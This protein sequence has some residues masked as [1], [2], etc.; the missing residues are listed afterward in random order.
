VSLI[1]ESLRAGYA[2]ATPVLDG[3]TVSVERGSVVALLGPN[4]SGKSTLTRC[5]ARALRPLGGRV[6]A[7]GDDLWALPAREAA[8]RV[9]YVGQENPMPFAFTVAELVRL[10]A[11]AASAGAAER[12]A[13][14][15]DAMEVAHLAGRSVVALSGGERQRA[16]VA[17]ALAQDADYLLL[18][19]PTAHLDLR[20]QAA[21]LRAAA[22]AKTTGKGVL[23]VLHD[24]SLAAHANKAVLLCDGAVLA[25]GPPRDVLTEDLLAQA[26]RTPVAVR[27]WAGPGQLAV[28][29][30][31]PETKSPDLPVG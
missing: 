2:P 7:D 23:L 11:E 26:Y 19:E 18:D 16:A 27:T 5:I 1:A 9:A 10:G 29:P 20:H 6:T 13:A 8:R 3:V 25:A 4:G 28:F 30:H 14:A 15:M 24:L 21:L 22:D 17:R 31:P 12:A